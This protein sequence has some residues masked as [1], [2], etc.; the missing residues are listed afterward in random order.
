MVM[1]TARLWVA[2][3][4]AVSSFLSGQAGAAGLEPQVNV[5]AGVLRAAPAGADGVVAFKGVPYAAPPV[6]HLRWHAPLAPLKWDGVRDAS[7]FGASCLSAWSGDREPGLRR[8]EDCLTLNVWTGAKAATERRPVMV[9]LHGGGFQFGT[10]ASAQFEGTPLARKG[11]VLVTLNYRVGVFGFLAHPALDREGPSGDYGLQDQLAALRWVKQNI[12]NF[13]G[14]PGNVTLFGESAGAH[15]IGILMASPS[16]KG[17]FHKAIGQSGAFWDG[18][19]GPLENRADAHARGT[20]FVQRLGGESIEALRGLSAEKLNA[21][22]MWD[23]SSNPAETAFSPNIDGY[24]VPQAPPATFAQ[25]KQMRIPLLAGWV[26]DEGYPFDALGLPHRNATEFRNAAQ[27]VF[28]KKRRAEFLRLY[29]AATNDQANVSANALTGDFVIGEQT[30]QW[31]EWQRLTKQPVYGYKFTYTSPYTPIAGH[32]T[33]VPFVF[34]TLTPQFILRSRTPAAPADRAMSEQVMA[35]W[36][37]FATNGNPNGPG[38]PQWPAYD[39][40][41]ML[42][43]LG[44]TIK[45]RA[46]DQARRFRFLSSFRRG[47]LLPEKWSGAV[48]RDRG[49]K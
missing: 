7:T 34:G 42:Q 8:S 30:W 36:V 32:I 43:E 21:A 15:A 38:L 29:P 16:S 22:A 27:A 6:G 37:N 33:D 2:T 19:N 49:E 45:P 12:A 4:L 28:G 23:F 14:D 39:A 25:G 9:W 26:A 46:N 1:K 13:G 24:V 44:P 20:A 48:V 3:S 11:V 10:G 18:P 31:L 40:R 5:P 47:G 35:Y 17:L 41:G